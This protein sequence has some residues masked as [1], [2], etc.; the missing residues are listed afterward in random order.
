ME[1]TTKIYHCAK[2]NASLVE[3]EIQSDK[4]KGSLKISK[5]ISQYVAINVISPLTSSTVQSVNVAS[6][7]IMCI[8]CFKE[9]AGQFYIDEL[10]LEQ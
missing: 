2:C 5:I 6:T 10:K 4:E 7:L 9:D 3:A 1:T 8:N